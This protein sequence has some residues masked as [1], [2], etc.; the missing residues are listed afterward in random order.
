MFHITYLAVVLCAKMLSLK[1]KRQH[2]ITT[3]RHGGGSI[4]AWA[5]YFE[6]SSTLPGHL[7][8]SGFSISNQAKPSIK[9]DY[10]LDKLTQDL[11]IEA[12][13]CSHERGDIWEQ[14]N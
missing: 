10:E 13:V 14:S 3:L 1:E 9:G 2:I 4:L 5:L 11:S 8:F 12:R 7:S 6:A